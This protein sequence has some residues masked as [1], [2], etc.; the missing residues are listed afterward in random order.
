MS[1]IEKQNIIAAILMLAI[2]IIGCVVAAY[3]LK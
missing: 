2:T 3:L 1:K